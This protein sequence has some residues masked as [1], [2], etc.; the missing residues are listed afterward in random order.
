MS[1]IGG[2]FRRAVTAVAN[3]LWS[4]Q[5]STTD[6]DTKTDNMYHDGNIGIGDFS[7]QTID[8]NL[9]VKTDGG[10]GITISNTGASQTSPFLTFDNPDNANETILT[11]RDGSVL[12][13]EYPE[14]TQYLSIDEDGQVQADFYGNGT[15]TGVPAFDLQVDAAGN[16]IETA[17]S[18]T[19]TLNVTRE[20]IIVGFASGY[21]STTTT[22][23]SRNCTITRTAVGRYTVTFNSPHPDGN[24]YEVITGAE[25]D[26]NRD[27]PKISVVEGTRT[28]NGFNIIVTVDDNGGTADSYNDEPFSFEV[29]REISVVINV[30]LV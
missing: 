2:F 22:L 15:L 17:I 3:A 1:N 18:T 8:D 6:A 29:L 26:A 7:S 19:P 10:A 20:D 12:N 23:Q 30:V 16:F 4:K 24:N 25:E 13:I 14:G 21:Q 11:P 28:A 27:I 5:N 9:V